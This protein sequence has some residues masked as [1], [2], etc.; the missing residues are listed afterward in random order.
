MSH[1][2]SACGRWGSRVTSKGGHLLSRSGRPTFRYLACVA[3]LG[4]IAAV[5]P[6]QLPAAAGHAAGSCLDVTAPGDNPEDPTTAI[7]TAVV[8]TATLR[9]PDGTACTGAPAR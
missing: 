6:F 5:L 7:N 8:Y 1:L 9:V 2:P 4:L 3:V